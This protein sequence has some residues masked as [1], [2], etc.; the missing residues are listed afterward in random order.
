ME[1]ISQEK[2]EALRLFNFVQN[3]TTRKNWE[4]M[5]ALWIGEAVGFTEW[6]RPVSE[7]KKTQSISI[8]LEG[9]NEET[10]WKVFEFL[11]LELEKG[12]TEEEIK[13]DFGHHFEQENLQIDRRTLNYIIGSGNNEYY[14]SLTITNET[15]LVYVNLMNYAPA[16]RTL[17]NSLSKLY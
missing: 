10:V 5:G 4:Y 2:F 12:M 14:L 16:I 15:G 9:L 17:K 11:G 13:T 7:P 1:L 8:D 3:Y 6:L